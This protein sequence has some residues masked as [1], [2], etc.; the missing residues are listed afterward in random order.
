MA[1]VGY[2]FSGGYNLSKTQYYLKMSSKHKL[3]A[4]YYLNQAD[5]YE[6]QKDY[7]NAIIMRQKSSDEISKALESDNNAS[8][9]ANGVH[10]EYINKDVILLQTTLKLLEVEI[11]S[12]REQNHELKPGQED[13][14]LNALNPYINE[15]KGTVSTYKN[16]ENEIIAKNPDKFKF[17]E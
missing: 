7:A 8:Y 13:T 17:I 9:Y 15:L 12:D 2:E 6:N 1:S 14:G 10:E 3:D 11:Y 4:N 16:E 5:A